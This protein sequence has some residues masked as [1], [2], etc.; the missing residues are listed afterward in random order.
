MT[1]TELLEDYIKRSGYKK[2]HIAKVVGLSA[3]GLALK[4]KN[5]NEFTTGEVDGLC[6]LLGVESLEEK[7]RIFFAK[8]VDSKSISEEEASE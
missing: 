6:K 1:N 2:S 3:Y 7:E 4:I 8:E 5:V